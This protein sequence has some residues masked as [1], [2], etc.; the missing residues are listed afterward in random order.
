M[1][2]DTTDDETGSTSTA[3]SAETDH[4]TEEEK[5]TAR[6]ACTR[7][8]EWDEMFPCVPKRKRVESFVASEPEEEAEFL[9]YYD[10]GP[11]FARENDYD[12]LW[13]L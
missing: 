2:W 4:I 1:T 11:A 6:H 10:D 3:P 9:G 7:A 13:N 12:W 8:P 5:E